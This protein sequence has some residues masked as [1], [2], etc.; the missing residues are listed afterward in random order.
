MSG[1]DQT[2][3]TQ[4]VEQLDSNQALVSQQ[5]D[6][7]VTDNQETQNETSETPTEPDAE[8]SGESVSAPD[9]SVASDEQQAEQPDADGEKELSAPAVVTEET[10]PAST[11]PEQAESVAETEIALSEESVVEPAAEVV[12]TVEQVTAVQTPS[13]L[14][15]STTRYLEEEGGFEV[16]T[17]DGVV[18]IKP[19]ELPTQT[20]SIVEQQKVILTELNNEIER[21]LEDV[22][23]IKRV[24]FEQIKQ[25]MEDMAPKKPVSIELGKKHQRVLIGAIRQILNQVD[26]EGTFT[27]QFAA[28]LK[29]FHIGQQHALGELYVFRFLE[30]V[31]M[32]NNDIEAFTRIV[33]M[34]LVTADAKSRQQA[35]KQLDFE[36]SLR[37]GLSDQ[38]RR[39][40][41]DFYGV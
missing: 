23:A 35:V 10:P 4:N 13:D 6:E 22:P 20:P 19:S 12:E 3:D 37:F 33:N 28:L 25:Y 18:I 11:E 7:Q 8:V 41:L 17:A 40:I 30:H 36:K 27:Q 31:E 5:P 2:Q 1:E 39:R 16:Q 29:I 34:L 32:Q 21:L 14:T 24:P 38:A 15:T 9:E 26:D